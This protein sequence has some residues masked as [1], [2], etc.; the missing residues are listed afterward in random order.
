MRYKRCKLCGCIIYDDFNDS[1]VCEVCEDDMNDSKDG[2]N[3]GTG[4]K[5]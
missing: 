1:G 4:E 2:E 5:F 3:N